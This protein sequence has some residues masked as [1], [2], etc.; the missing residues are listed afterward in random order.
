MELLT[1]GIG[2]IFWQTVVFLILVFLLAKFAWRPILDSLKIREESIQEA[3]QAAENARLEMTDLQADNDK[4]LAAARA[5]REA[6][7]KEAVQVAKAIKEEAKEDAAKMGQKIIEDAKA[8]IEA[9]KASALAEVRTLVV[10]LSVE[11]AEKVIRKSL[12]DEESQ[13]ALVAEFLADKN[14][15]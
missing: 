7:M 13:K 3:L 10:D 14:I 11:M 6:L 4:L 12:G 2:L 1:P 8:G 5:E 9:E 15:N